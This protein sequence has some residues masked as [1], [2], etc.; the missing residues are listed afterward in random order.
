MVGNRLLLFFN[1]RSEVVIPIHASCPHYSCVQLEG[2]QKLT[3]SALE[4]NSE[5]TL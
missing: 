3:Q 2:T 4:E 5:V 1:E